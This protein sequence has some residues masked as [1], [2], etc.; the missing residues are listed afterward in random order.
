M[1]SEVRW[2]RGIG[3]VTEDGG[4]ELGPFRNVVGGLEGTECVCDGFVG[5]GESYGVS[6]WCW[7]CVCHGCCVCVCKT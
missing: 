7:W 4:A 6:C 1:S 2:R 5:G 3:L